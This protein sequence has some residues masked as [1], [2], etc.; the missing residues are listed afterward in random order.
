MKK[1][2][3]IKKERSR[4]KVFDPFVEY[5]LDVYYNGVDHLQSD[6]R[7]KYRRVFREEME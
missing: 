4:I 6:K 5:V 7:T 3:H 1:F 2:T